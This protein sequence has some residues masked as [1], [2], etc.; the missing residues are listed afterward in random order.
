[1]IVIAGNTYTII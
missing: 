1:M